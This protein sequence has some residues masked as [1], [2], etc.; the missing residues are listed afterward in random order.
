MY[1]QIMY[2][3]GFNFVG[4]FGQIGWYEYREEEWEE[5]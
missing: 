3:G 5:I 4:V 1:V 2:V